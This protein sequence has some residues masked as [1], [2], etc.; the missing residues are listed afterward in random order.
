MEDAASNMFSAEQIK[1]LDQTG[2]KAADAKYQQIMNPLLEKLETTE[3]KIEETRAKG[4]RGG[5]LYGVLTGL[6][7][8]AASS[9][10][11]PAAFA[12]V[13][14]A[15]F[16]LAGGGLGA[17]AGFNVAKFFTKAEKELTDAA[18]AQRKEIATKMESDA[19]TRD[20]WNAFHSSIESSIASTRGRDHLSS[21]LHAYYSH[22]NSC[23]SLDLSCGHK[24]LEIK[25]RIDLANFKE[26]KIEE[27]VRLKLLAEKNEQKEAAPTSL[28]EKV[29][30]PA[31]DTQLDANPAHKAQAI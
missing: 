30:P 19:T 22:E 24:Q 3:A 28:V 1:A 18:K 5:I 14:G 7:L 21:H 25:N 12:L 15:T 20:I 27:L 4:G 16:A 2:A 11:A 29:R 31:S 17:A 10:L 26:D 6:V 23:P 13:G 9:F 8:A